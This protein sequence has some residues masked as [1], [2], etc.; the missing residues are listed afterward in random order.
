VNAMDFEP[1]LIGAVL[2]AAMTLGGIGAAPI[3]AKIDAS[4]PETFAATCR[5]AAWAVVIIAASGLAISTQLTGAVGLWLWPLAKT[6]AIGAVALYVAA[7]AARVLIARFVLPGVSGW[8]RAHRISQSTDALADIRTEQARYVPKSFDPRRYFVETGTTKQPGLFL[9]LDDQGKALFLPWPVFRETHLQIIGPTRY[10]KGVVAGCILAQSIRAGFGS[11]YFDPK[12]DNHIPKIMAE[13]AKATGRPFVILDLVNNLGAYAPFAGGSL[14]DRI[15]RIVQ[16][17]KLE[18]TGSDGDYYKRSERK[19]IRLALERVP[20]DNATLANILKA[21]QQV[22]FQELG[23]DERR[24]AQETSVESGL[25]EWAGIPNITG[26]GQTGLRVQEALDSNAVVYVR[27]STK[28]LARDV[29]RILL[30]ELAETALKSPPAA[31]G[32]H[33]FMLVDE[34]RSMISSPLISAL[35]TVAGAG[36]TVGLAYQSILDMRNMDD[37]RLDA[38]SV[39]GAVNVNCQVKILYGTTDFD[40]AKWISQTSGTR[41]VFLAQLEKAET[42]AFGGEKWGSD[43]S[44]REDEAPLISPNTVLALKPRVAVTLIPG[45]PAQMLFPAWMPYTTTAWDEACAAHAQVTPA[46]P[47]TRK[48]AVPLPSDHNSHDMLALPKKAPAAPAAS[49]EPE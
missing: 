40:T 45:S 29:A 20:A 27:C 7:F 18:D 39:E 31:D 10:G 9:G 8:M 12:E 17:Y 16:A 37:K 46:P 41:R 6:T 19:M 32:R 28:G 14:Q 48:K 44:F 34:A 36:M 43:R 3:Q 49:D 30:T 1:W 26:N 25:A 23:G 24:V 2:S 22:K 47:Q 15:G 5:R 42:S 33:A 13:Q 35:T 38:G 21:F 4:T 11:W